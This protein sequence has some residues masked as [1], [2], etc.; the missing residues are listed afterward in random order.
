[1][2]A[3]CLIAALVLFT[4]VY[5]NGPAFSP[6][7]GTR[8]WSLSTQ[9]RAQPADQDLASLP[10]AELFVPGPPPAEVVQRVDHILPPAQSIALNVCPLHRPPPAPRA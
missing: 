6:A 4:V 8:G 5:R 10:V 9:D 3:G 2:T 7:N 1:M